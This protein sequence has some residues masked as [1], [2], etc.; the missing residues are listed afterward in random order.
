V[1]QG[2]DDEYG[3]EAQVQAIARGVAGPVRS[4]ILPGLRHTPHREDPGAV[5]R[6]V[7]EHL[8]GAKLIPGGAG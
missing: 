3:T 2:S 5:L 6:L 1:L 7:A 8:E 4:V